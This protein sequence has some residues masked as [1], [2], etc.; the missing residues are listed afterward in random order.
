MQ[1]IGD[2]WLS[3][4][5]GIVVK[6]EE[7]LRRQLQIKGESN[8]KDKEKKAWIIRRIL[9]DSSAKGEK[10]IIKLVN[11]SV[12]SNAKGGIIV[13]ILFKEC[14]SERLMFNW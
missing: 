4:T 14:Y 12:V 13:K 9:D 11:D 6:G 10:I 7:E 8:W 3:G 1:N 5:F 2:S